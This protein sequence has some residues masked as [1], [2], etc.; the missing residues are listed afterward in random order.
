MAAKQKPDDTEVVPRSLAAE[1]ILHADL[2][3]AR[4]ALSVQGLA[5]NARI[6]RAR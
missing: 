6:V 5:L 4:V 3:D 1:G 2:R